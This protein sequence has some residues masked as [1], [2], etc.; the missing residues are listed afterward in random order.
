MERCAAIENGYSTRV[1]SR[2]KTL[3]GHRSGLLERLPE[4]DPD[5]GEVGGAAGRDGGEGQPRV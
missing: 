1:Q 4:A 2:A 3:E 5:D